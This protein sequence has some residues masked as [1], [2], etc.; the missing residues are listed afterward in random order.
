MNQC[1][2]DGCS[3]PVKA[4]SLCDKHYREWR[5][6]NPERIFE[7]A[8]NRN[9]ECSVEG[10]KKPAFSKGY[11]TKHY[12]ALRRHGDAEYRPQ[13]SGGA[14][15]RHKRTYRSYSSMK[16]RVLNK[17]HIQYKDYGG[18]GISICDRWLEKPEGFKN[19][20]NDMGERPEGRSLDRI[21]NDGDYCPQNCKWSTPKEQAAN[22]RQSIHHARNAKIF[23][24]Y[25]EELLTIRELS[26]KTGEPMSTLYNK[27]M[28]KKLTIVKK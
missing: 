19:F 4:R 5:K 17:N 9:R 6:S 10:C 26:E 16:A 1:K 23:V 27:S 14:W 18:R 24:K 13:N 15:K 7:W 25:G 21:N 11:C 22:R 8:R 3:S 12:A 20:L 28:R 2:S